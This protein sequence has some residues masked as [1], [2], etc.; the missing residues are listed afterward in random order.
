MGAGHPS[1]TNSSAFATFEKERI[2]TRIREVKQ[3]KKSQ[4]KFTGGKAG[5]G[6]EVI[7]GVKVANKDQQKVI[8]EMRR[9][10]TRG[11]SYR[12]IATWL[13]KNKGVEMTFMGVRRLLSSF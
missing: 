10:K 11:K 13:E 9:L 5:F 4:G 12:Y 1:L 2:A 3:I 8:S 6:Y 7:D